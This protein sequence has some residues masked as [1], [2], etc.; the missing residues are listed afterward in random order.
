MNFKFT[1][2]KVIVSLILGVLAFIVRS[3]LFQLFG[4]IFG[5]A[6]I[7]ESRF[8]LFSEVNDGL[9]A[10]AVAIVLT[11]VIWSFI[12]KKVE[13]VQSVEEKPTKP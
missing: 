3:T 4:S 11:Y 9:Q 1:K 2:A 5:L 12:Q 13:T 6:S 10:G 7:G 8:R